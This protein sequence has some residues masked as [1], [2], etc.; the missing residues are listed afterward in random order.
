MSSKL[1]GK[2]AI[3]TGGAGGLGKGIVERFKNDGADVIL[4]DFVEEVG[5]KTAEEL[6]V[7]FFKCDVTSREDWEAVVKFAHEKF[8]RIDAVVN[9]AGWTYSNKSTLEVTDA[10]FDKVFAVNVKAIYYSANAVVPYMQK[11]GQGG[12]FVT[13]ASTAG[14]RPR[15]GLTWYNATKAAVINATKSMAVEYAKD[16]IRFNNVCPVVALGT[17]LT[18][19]FLGNPGNEKTFMATI[20][21]GRGSTPKDIGNACAFLCYPE[22]NFLTGIDIPVDGGRC[23]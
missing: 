17:G 5:K 20:P 6:K 3:I 18:N 1:S 23:V 16:N 10:E 19:S 8:G 14:I 11:Q 4:A 13:I 7:E 21:L 22:S 12:S 15:G 9:N 2:V